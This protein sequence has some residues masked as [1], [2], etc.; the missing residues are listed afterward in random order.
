MSMIEVEC[1]ARKW[2]SSLGVILPK[3]IV[4]REHIE[5]ND[6]VIVAIKKIHRVSEFFGLL[7]DWK[8]D[9]QKKKDELRSGW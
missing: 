3:E 2:G 8:I 9:T 5:T 4:K 1:I 7:P 6:K